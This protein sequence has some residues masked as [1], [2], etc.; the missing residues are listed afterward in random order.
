[1]TLCFRWAEKGTQYKR[2][3]YFYFLKNVFYKNV[4]KYK[5]LQIADDIQ[6]KKHLHSIFVS[7][8]N[9]TQKY[10]SFIICKTYKNM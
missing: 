5:N 3:K 2:Y 7:K 6:F 8:N 10:V 4:K 1:M 9:L